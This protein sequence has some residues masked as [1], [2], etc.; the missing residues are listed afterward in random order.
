MYTEITGRNEDGTPSSVFTNDG[1]A[2]VSRPYEADRDGWMEN[3]LDPAE[4]EAIRT[5]YQMEQLV[6]MVNSLRRENFD[7]KQDLKMW[8]KSAGFGV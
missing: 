1:F 5:G 8:K 3:Q 6:H 4:F 2:Q 7:L